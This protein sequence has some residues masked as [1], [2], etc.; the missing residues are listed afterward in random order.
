M[1]E[2]NHSCSV[3][4]DV[5]T[6][7]TDSGPIE[8]NVREAIILSP[9]V[10]EQLSV[11]ECARTFALKNIKAINSV[12]DLLS[13]EV[14]SIMKLPRG[15][16]FYQKNSCLEFEQAL[17]EADDLEQDSV[18]ISRLSVESLEEFV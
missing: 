3:F 13:C 1:T 18:N 11:D 2:I 10:R 17:S 14:F 15:F 16:G 12:H 5:F 9:A 6:F 4:T 7:S 8:C